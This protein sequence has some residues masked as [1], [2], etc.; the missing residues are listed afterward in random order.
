MENV[1]IQDVLPLFKQGMEVEYVI[2]EHEINRSWKRLVAT[3][4]LLKDSGH[5]RLVVYANDLPENEY[6]VLDYKEAIEHYN[7]IK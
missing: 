7:K 6:S 1:T 4:T 5:V 3:T 2:A